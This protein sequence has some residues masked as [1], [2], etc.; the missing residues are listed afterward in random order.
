[1]DAF[2]QYM[3]ALIETGE[4]YV[5][6]IPI[7]VVLLVGERI[8]HEVMEEVK[9]DHRDSAANIAITAAFLSVDLVVGKLLP[10]GL[11][12]AIYEHARL[13]ELG[14]SVTGWVAAFLLYDL[15]W[16][17]DHRISHRVGF[18]WAMHHV[19]HSSNQYNMTVASRGFVVDKTLLSRPLFYLLPILG[20]APAHFIVILIVTN[21]W[22]IAQHTR[23]IKRLGPLDWLLATPS[24][25]R[26]HHGAD[27]KYLDKN[28]GEVLIIWDRLFGTY[29]QEQEEPTYGVTERIE[30]YNPL[31]IEVAG[32]KWFARKL[33]RATNWRDWWLCFVMPPG[34]EPAQNPRVA[35]V[36][37]ESHR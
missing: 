9:W 14:Q 34:W 13:F 36:D 28:Y 37:N 27:D 33:R 32:F 25:H 35:F 16:Y 4:S 5:F 18:F 12:A 6:L 11:V 24:N 29:Q 21:V 7:Y 30:T 23:L 17:V 8:A 10:L 26:V 1:M 20:V 31:E 19:H 22:G 2:F 15:A 3:I